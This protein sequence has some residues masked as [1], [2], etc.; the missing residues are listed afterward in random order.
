MIILNPIQS[1]DFLYNF[2]VDPQTN[3]LKLFLEKVI[4]NQT[5]IKGKHVKNSMLLYY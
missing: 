2:K 5:V 1:F 4:G 3:G